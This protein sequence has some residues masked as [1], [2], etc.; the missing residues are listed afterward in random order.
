ML[1]GGGGH[2][3]DQL[4]DSYDVVVLG[5]GAA[6][7]N[8]AM[9]LA[10]SRRRVVV[11]DA[12]APRNAPAE[13]VHGLLGHDGIPPAELLERGRSEVR[14]YGG[15]VVTGEVTGA[16]RDD[17]A[18][19]RDAGRR[20][21]HPRAP[22]AGDDRPGRRTAGGARGPRALGTRRPA[23]PLLPR[24]GGPGPG[25][26]DPGDRTDVGAPGPAVPP[27]ERRRHLPRPRRA[28]RRRTRRAAGGPAAS[29]SWTVRL[30]RWRSWTTGSWACG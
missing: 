6:G 26:R 20:Q 19:H 9:M 22:T 28:A 21:L 15:H 14:R 12:G 8:G 17:R 27:A 23:L 11:I 30:R 16:A 2:M 10:R 5:G 25:H 7:L 1:V 29:P 24:L 3:T 13:G 4:E 18:V